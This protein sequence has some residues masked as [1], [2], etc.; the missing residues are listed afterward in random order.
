MLLCCAVG[1]G[2]SGVELPTE[3][4]LWESVDR[5]IQYEQEQVR[6]PEAS[7]GSPSG[8][9]RVFS[10]VSHPTYSI[11]RA[12]ESKANGVGLVIC[13]G[14]GYRDVWLDR[15]GHDLGIWLKDRGITSLIL[16]YRTNTGN[17]QSQPYSWEEYLPVVRSDARQAIRVLR[18]QA[19]SLHVDSKKIGICG[20]SAGGNLAVLAMLHAEPK[21]ADHVSGTPDFA[22]LFYP[23]LREDYTDLIA[24]RSVDNVSSGTKIPPVFIMNAGDDRVTPADQCVDFYAKLVKA[25]VS[26]ELHVFSKGSHGFDLGVGRGASAALWPN[27][28][29]SWL[30]DVS[31]IE[32]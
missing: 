21:P 2:A 13:P 9:N 18:R 32:E 24:S 23:W 8:S 12:P 7:P 5:A 22:G 15:E 11:H 10:Y 27:S 3:Q 29:V 30:R 6:T 4:P 25:G 1:F 28:F 14:G 20:F 26:A 31:F 17:G 16:K 19:S